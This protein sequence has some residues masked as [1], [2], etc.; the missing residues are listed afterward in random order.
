[1][2]GIS[3]GKATK[4]IKGGTILNEMVTPNF[5]CYNCGEKRHIKI[6]CPNI[7]KEKEKVDDREKEKKTK[8]RCAYIAWEDNHDSTSSSS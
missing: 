6:E 4:V 5:C 1:L 8:E 2:E 7:N 3:R